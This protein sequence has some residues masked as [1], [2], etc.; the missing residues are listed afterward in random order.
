MHFLKSSVLALR[1]HDGFPSVFI[2]FAIF[3]LLVGIAHFNKTGC[4]QT[5]EVNG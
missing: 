4:F 1:Q 5:Y 3:R 2:C